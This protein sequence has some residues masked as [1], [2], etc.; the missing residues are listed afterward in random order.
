MRHAAKL[1]VI[2]A[3]MAGQGAAADDHV[4]P[5]APEPVFSLA[6]G[7][8]YSDSGAGSTQLD[9]D[10]SAEVDEELGPIDDFLRDLTSRANRV[11][12]EGADRRTIADCV[13]AQMAVWARDDAMG[14]LQSTTSQLT[15][16]SRLSAFGMAALQTAPFTTRTAD[17]AEVRGWLNRRQR[18]QMAFWETGPNGAKGG[19]LRAWSALAA[20]AIGDLSND[21]LMLGW[22]AWSASYILCTANED[23]SLPQEMGR[24]RFALHYQLHAIAPLVVT[25]ALL[26]RQGTPVDGECDDALHRAVGFAARDLDTGAQSQAITGEVQ[27]FFDGTDELEAFNLAWIE[28]YLTLRHD[29]GLADR[30]APLRPLGHS[31]LG[32]DQTAIWGGAG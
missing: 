32:G 19:N 13:I 23:G 8:R 16:G 5:P 18:A 26:R 25:A 12:D 28:A 9:T 11:F 2:M 21:A 1:A 31:K 15:I 27:T 30:A 24:G 29:P 20:N 14:D 17:L 10:A 4:C 22:S 3:I 6:Y 7:S